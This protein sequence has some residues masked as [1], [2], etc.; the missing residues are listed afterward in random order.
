M[1]MML[2]YKV[3]EE[4]EWGF[5]NLL[6][7]YGPAQSSEVVEANNKFKGKML[8]GLKE[9]PRLNLRRAFWRWY[10]RSTDSGNDLILR[11]ANQLVLYT[12]INKTT[13]FYRLLKTV[14]SKVRVSPKMKR[15]TTMLYLY[16][17]IYFDRTKRYAFDNMRVEGKS[18]KIFALDRLFDRARKRRISAF[19]IWMA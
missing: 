10:I 12:N 9:Y 15:M 1:T 14:R 8:M 17:R 19:K 13:A 7:N 5:R 3:N 4:I 11:A 16:L 2:N 6:K 18:N